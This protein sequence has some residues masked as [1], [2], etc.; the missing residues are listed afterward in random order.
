MDI[1]LLTGPGWLRR[2]ND[3][4]RTGRSGDRI[5]VRARFSTLVQT[6]PGAHP[7]SYTV[8]TGAFAGLKRPGRGAGHPLPSSAENKEI[9]YQ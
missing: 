5:P 4:L 3:L 1:W 6:G 7:G 8:G 2:Y 9:V